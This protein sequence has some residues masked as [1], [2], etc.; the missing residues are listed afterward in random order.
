[1]IVSDCL[2]RSPSQQID[3]K[4]ENEVNLYVDS[5]SAHMP[6]SDT[7]LKRIYD[8]TKNDSEIQQVISITRKG[9]PETGKNL[10]GSISEYFSARNEFSLVDGLLLYR[11]RLVIPISQRMEVLE[12]LHMSHQGL[13]KSKDFAAQC[14]WWPTI[15]KD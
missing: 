13:T 7:R 9:W 3:C 8:A 5:V 2:S 11:N 10:S 1:M 14:V 6:I 15:N 4:I 12:K